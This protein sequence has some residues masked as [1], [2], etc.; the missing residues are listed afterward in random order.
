MSTPFDDVLAGFRLGESETLLRLDGIDDFRRA[1]LV[2]VQQVRRE[3]F[4][5]T[6]DFEPERYNQ[7]DF[8]EALSAFV[9]RQRQADARILLGDPAIAVRWGH[10]IVALAQRLTTRLRIRQLNEEDIDP[11]EAWMVA[12]DIGLLR[13]DGSEGFKGMLAAKAIPQ[14]QRATLRFNELWERSRDIPDFRRLHI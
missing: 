2:L 13:R 10:R 6:P 5:V 11:E 12:D 1:Q 7:A 9:R 8:S 4:I 3:L 14:A